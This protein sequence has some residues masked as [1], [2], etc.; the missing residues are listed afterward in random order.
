LRI[1]IS[2]AA[3]MAN[4]IAIAVSVFSGASAAAALLARSSCATHP[5]WALGP[6]LG[7]D[8][9]ETNGPTEW[10]LGGRQGRRRVPHPVHLDEGQADQGIDLGNRSAT[11]V[12]VGLLWVVRTSA[13]WRAIQM[14]LPRLASVGGRT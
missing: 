2:P 6:L 7:E 14:P 8:L 12:P 13:R 3:L 9:K 10:P 1:V 11:V 5:G 4:R